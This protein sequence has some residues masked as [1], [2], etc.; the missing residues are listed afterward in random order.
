MVRFPPSYFQTLKQ[1]LVSKE[2]PVERTSSGDGLRSGSTQ[3][4]DSEVAAA[5]AA[6]EDSLS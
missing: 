3:V 6:L 2:K 1:E 5:A 4:P